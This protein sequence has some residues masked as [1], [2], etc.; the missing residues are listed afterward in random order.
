ME[1]TC[2]MIRDKFELNWKKDMEL[3]ILYPL[4]FQRNRSKV[5]IIKLNR[6][7]HLLYILIKVE[8]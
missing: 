1:L 5:S 7:T 8:R 3:R 6:T 2:L 4:R